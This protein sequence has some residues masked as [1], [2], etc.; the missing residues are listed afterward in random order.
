MIVKLRARDSKGNTERFSD[1]KI[2]PYIIENNEVIK[3]EKSY[4]IRKTT[5]RVINDSLFK[6]Y[7][8]GNI[9]KLGEDI[10]EETD[11]ITKNAN[12]II[13]KFN[14][15]FK[16]KYH[17]EEIKDDLEKGFKD[18][19]VVVTSKEK[20]YDELKVKLYKEHMESLIKKGVFKPL[21]ASLLYELVKEIDKL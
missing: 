17:M 18:A 1:I 7:T 20:V 11:L 8:G 16:D 21:T 19:F 4:S 2:N 10:K 14:E 13:E 9:I 3:S 6:L 12:L 5:G 15:K